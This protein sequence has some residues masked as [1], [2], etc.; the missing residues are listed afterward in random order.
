MNPVKDYNDI[1]TDIKK[2]CE[3]HGTVTVGILI[4]DGYQQDAREYILHYANM[5]DRHSDGYIDFF[6]PGYYINASS[7]QEAKRIRSFHPNADIRIESN[8][9]SDV[10]FLERTGLHYG[11]D[12]GL[13][14]RFLDN[15]HDRMG[16]AITYNPML[17]LVEVN[18]DMCRGE[19][20]FQKKLVIELDSNSDGNIRRAGML[21]E[22]IFEIAKKNINL[23]KF[24]DG[25]R[26]RYLKKNCID[27]ISDLLVRDYGGALK[28]LGN[29][30]AS[31]RLQ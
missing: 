24:R 15:I 12:Q 2:I 11:Y 7:E 10:I 13:F 28:V 26:L 22:D 8:K 14:F 1:Y 19:L 5:F 30:V 4:A 21:F 9:Y 29:G 16:I 17:I 25:I 23:Y 20:E 31:Y 6:I 27:L 3:E 18:M